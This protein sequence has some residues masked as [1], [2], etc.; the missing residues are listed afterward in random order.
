MS[1]KK[2]RLVNEIPGI[3]AAVIVVAV[4]VKPF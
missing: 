2:L 4:I 3:A 1:E